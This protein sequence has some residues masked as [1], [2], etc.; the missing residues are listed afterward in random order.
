[1]HPLDPF[2]SQEQVQVSGDR[3][4]FTGVVGLAQLWADSPQAAINFASPKQPKVSTD[5]PRQRVVVYGG[6]AFLLLAG[7]FFLR[8]VVLDSKKAQVDEART[9][10]TRLENT[11]KQMEPIGAKVA[12]LNEW[13][14]SALPW[15]EE[16]YN[17]TAHFPYEVGFK[18][19]QVNVT[20]LNQ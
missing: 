4:G 14:D 3:G 5:T 17:L 20:P 2:A 15:L 10:L 7:C 6:L 13:Q 18:T 11:L 16:I 9:D 1:V 12:E 19:T 8:S